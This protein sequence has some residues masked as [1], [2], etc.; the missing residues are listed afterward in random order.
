MN[1]SNK[2][3][4]VIRSLTG[5]G[6][7]RVVS[8]LSSY[9]ANDG[10]DVSIIAYDKSENDYEISTKVKI[11][12]MPSDRK[13]LH[14]KI[15]RIFDMRRLIQ[16]AA[17]DVII[18]FV[19]TVLFVSYLAS[20]YANIPFIRTV[21]ISPWMEANSWIEKK[22]L[23]IMDQ[24]AAA[25]MIQNSEQRDYFPQKYQNKIFEVPNPVAEDFLQ[26][27]KSTYHK[28]IKRIVTAGRLTK[29]KNHALL[30]QAVAVLAKDNP[31]IRLEIYGTGKERSNLVELIRKLKMENH[32]FLMG[33]SSDL[34]SIYTESDLFV[35][36]SD[37]EGMP[38]ALMEAMATG[39]PC[40]SSDCMTGPRSLI[41]D[42]KT[43]LLFRTGDLD[44]LIVQLKWAVT[45]SA[46]LKEIG[47]AGK[48]EM[49]TKYTCST[50]YANMLS[51]L[52][53]I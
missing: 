38:N 2:Y 33:R 10:Y 35:M 5:G 37:F 8:V 50:I 6:A 42:K 26:I 40:L 1:K 25:I 47:E 49:K 24:K 34:A 4:F 18:P 16:E 11:Y 19:G 41:E 46:L 22:L 53:H 44:S 7:E 29:Q 45:H 32:C 15:Q 17:P 12:Y 51:M 9:M 31:N 21:R 39:L 43:G 27:E 48:N 3:L 13:G 23:E 14:G 28:E 20:R 36:C 52:N 30:I